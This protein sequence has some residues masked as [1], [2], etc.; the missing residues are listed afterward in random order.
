MKLYN[1]LKAYSVFD[2]ELAYCQGTNYIAAN[3]AYNI[4]NENSCFWMYY[5]IMNKFDWRR[6]FLDNSNYLIKKLEK[7][8]I[9]LEEKIP[10]LYNYFQEIDVNLNYKL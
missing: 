5:Q 4:I 3:L 9:I 6:L 8:V 2:F 10:I 1:I 7:F